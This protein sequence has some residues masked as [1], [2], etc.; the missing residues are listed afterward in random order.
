MHIE[1]ALLNTSRDIASCFKYI[2]SYQVYF[3]HNHIHKINSFDNSNNLHSINIKNIMTIEHPYD[4]G[5][6]L[7]GKKPEDDAPPLQKNKIQ[8]L[9]INYYLLQKKKIRGPNI[10]RQIQIRLN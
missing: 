5:D 9:I 6:A 7:E 3:H 10:R 2:I 1:G 8:N 4:G